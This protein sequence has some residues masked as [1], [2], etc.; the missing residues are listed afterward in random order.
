MLSFLIGISILM[1]SCTQEEMAY[2]SS[3]SIQDG[4][5]KIHLHTPDLQTPTLRSMDNQA[6]NA[7]DKSLLNVLVF[8]YQGNG[9]EV[10]QYRAP[11][12]GSIKYNKDDSSKAEIT[13]KLVESISSEDQYRIVVVANYDFSD[14]D[15][16]KDV[17]S[18]S[19]ILE[20]LTYSLPGKWNADT[21]NYSRFPMWGENAPITISDGMAYPEINLYRALARVDIG[22]NFSAENGKLTEQAE[23]LSEF[24]IKEVFVYRTYNMG[25]VA[26]LNTDFT[27]TPS[28]PSGAERHKDTSP[29]SYKIPDGGA[30]R[31]VR[32]IYI[33][34]ADLPSSPDNGNTHCIVVGGYYKNSSAVSYYRLDF[35]REN[36]ETRSYLP[37]LRNHRYVFN[38]TQVR[39]PGAKSADIALKTHGT[40]ENLGYDLMVWDENIHEMEV[41]GKYYFGLDNR[42]LLFG[43][44]STVN[45]P[46]N[47]FSVK[48][49]TNYP[50]S[51]GDQLTLDWASRR[52]DLSSTPGFD[53]QW[54]M[55]D[56]R[57]LI[58]ANTDNATNGLL[59]DTLLVSAGPFV[60]KITVQQK[61]LN[62]KYSLD[63]A[64][65]S[66]NGSYKHGITLTEQHNIT[67]SII[68]D[69]RDMQG[70]PYVIKTADPLNHGISFRAEGRFDFS[71]IPDGEPLRINDIQ[72]IGSGTIQANEDEN[73]FSLAI[74]AN[75]SSGSAC[76]ATIQLV[77]PH[78]NI[79]VLAAPFQ[80]TSFGYAISDE[81]GGVYKVFNSQNNFGPKD[82]SIVKVEGFSYIS[83]STY[84][85]ESFDTENLQKWVT[86]DGNDGKIAD[87]IYIAHSATFNL[88][89][90]RLLVNYM[91]NGGVVVI[92]CHDHSV[93]NL[94]NAVL[95]VNNISG[96]QNGPG[97]FIY[98]FPANPFYDLNENDLQDVLRRFEGDPILNGPF[99]D[100]RDQ[101]WGK[102]NLNTTMNLLN[103]PSSDPDLTIYSYRGD[104]FANPNSE[105]LN[106]VN[107]FKYESE[108]RNM[109]WF[110]DGGFVASDEG[111]IPGTN[112]KSYPLNWNPDTFFPEPR[113]GYGNSTM[114]PVY[115]ST[116]FC[117]IMAWAIQKSESLRAKREQ[118][119]N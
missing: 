19:E 102:D 77:I 89:T 106:Y 69:S 51:D 48:Y 7:I 78:M 43:A 88:G 114:M 12:S 58:K 30:N 74:V 63:C 100:V 2:E 103:M 25:Y 54:Q 112:Q 44:K 40:I 97:G 24:K 82:N 55:Q 31:Y 23:G 93:A 76:E 111:G 73:M 49:D 18:K 8:K 116:V 81:N 45:D 75:C 41:Q 61:Y 34:E 4:Y 108:N 33:P 52:D 110:G 9:D 28:I 21:D 5:M 68:A 46:S 67:V 38:I 85:F 22:L 92:F 13:I 119:S 6:E 64:S 107:G 50:L 35:A 90:I 70:L 60:Q 95:D 47:V 109:V 113:P 94:A 96:N 91:D 1:Y 17:T 29:L 42:S 86:G 99:G 15:L 59:S 32:E 118:L 56:N 104:I 39:G 3:P 72:M 84:T 98:P 26:A 16:N 66:V 101:Q 115:N 117:N 80:S 14:I 20:Q 65:I 105:N 27:A 10:F 62:L 79:L 71:D 53:A 11:I 83:S 37:V 57:I 36:S 87:I